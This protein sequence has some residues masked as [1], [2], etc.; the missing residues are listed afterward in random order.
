[1]MIKITCPQCGVDGSISLLEP[2]YQGPY[3][4]WKCRTLF[5]LQ[6][7]DNKLKSCEP[8]SEEEFE[9]LQQFHSLKT[10]FKKD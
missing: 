10:K 5:S 8:I 6:L 2:N 9:R 7:E 4:C 1:M 3:K